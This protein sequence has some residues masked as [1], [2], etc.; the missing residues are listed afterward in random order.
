MLFLLLGMLFLTHPYSSLPFFVQVFDQISPSP[1]LSYLKWWAFLLPLSAFPSSNFGSPNSIF[2]YYFYCLLT[3][4]IIGIFKMS[5][6]FPAPL[7]FL[8]KSPSLHLVGPFQPGRAVS[9]RALVDHGD[10]LWCKPQ[11]AGGVRFPCGHCKRAP[12]M[13][14]VTGPV[15][16]TACGFFLIKNQT[17]FSPTYY[18]YS[19]FLVFKQ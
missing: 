6:S 17:S 15:V 4:N 9:I 3:C 10:P 2:S 5:F 8:Q 14:A 11:G 18:R 16:L 1:W 13:M 7:A 12:N 19:H